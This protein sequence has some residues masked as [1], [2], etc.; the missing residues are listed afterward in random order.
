M[1][2]WMAYVYQQKPCPTTF[3][4]VEVSL[5]VV[6]S[7]GNHRNIGK[8]TTEAS[9][10]FSYQWKPDIEGKYTVIASFAG[11][12]G[13]WPSSAETAFAVDP[14][15]PTTT[16]EYPKPI[17]NTMIMVGLGIAILAAIAVVGALI[18]ITLRKRS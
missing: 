5:D 11:T 9:G 6:D 10:F 1:T 3:K 16:P 14:A 15:V 18:L 13:Y 12:N 4:G 2:D 8:A 7:N 17:D